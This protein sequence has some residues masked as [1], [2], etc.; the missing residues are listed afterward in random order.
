[1][2]KIMR[3]VSC[4]VGLFLFFAIQVNFIQAD[5][6]SETGQKPRFTVTPIFPENQKQTNLGYFLLDMT[7]VST[8]TINVAIRNTSKQPITI[9]GEVA[10]A[11]TNSNGVI[12]YR[13]MDVEPDSSLQIQFEEIAMLRSIDHRLCLPELR[14]TALHRRQQKYKTKK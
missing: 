5:E 4:L 1:M 12:V 14:K 3:M 7:E 2:N 9:V 11:T 6:L 13:S 8:Q 10:T